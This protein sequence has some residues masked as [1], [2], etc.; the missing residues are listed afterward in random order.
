M[1]IGKVLIANRGEIAVRVIR[2]C[3]EAGI[4]TVAVYSEVDRQALHVLLA[5]EAYLIGPSPA[6]ES[7][8]AVDKLVHVA[9]RAGADAVHPGYGFLAENAAFAGACG[10]AGLVWIGPPPAAIRAMGDKTAARR[11]ARELGVP[12]VPGTLDAVAGDEAARAAARE[13]GYPVMIKAVLGGG[14]K[15]MRLVRREEEL[16]AALRMARGEA[17]SAFGDASI[18]LERALAEPRHIEIQILAD[19]HGHVV[20]LGER[21]CSI[22]RRHQKLVEECPSPLVDPGLRERLGTAAC[23]VARAAGYV[24]AGTV[25]FLVDGERNFYFLE[26]NTRLQVEHPVTE[27]VTGLDLVRE[28]LRIAA[29][30]P[31]SVRQADVSWRGWA[32]E[33]RINAEDPFA[34]WLPS[35]GTITALRLPAGPWVR[36]DAGVYEGV[37][38]PRFYDTLVAKLVVWGVDRAAA[39]DRVQRALDEYRV[40]GIRT[41]L[42]V[43]RRIVAHPDFRAGRLDTAFLDRL[44]PDLADGG[45][46]HAS[47]A[48]VAAVLAYYERL[49]RGVIPPAA[50]LSAWRRAAAE[51]PA[52]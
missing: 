49:G 33:C 6:A 39:I 34:G 48:L 21:E 17:G 35:P 40:A 36:N 50:P 44:L 43:L 16:A 22:Q 47:V 42:P 4:A 8:L 23:G 37:A 25:E 24:N 28:Q 3:R 14:G 32:I 20:H 9:K 13:L 2:A 45:G 31:L 30:E 11:L 29:G 51:G 27:L 18:Y 1:K 26:M 7:Y 10:D 38:I 19:A 5:D 52:S 46:R 15:G 12:T 41:T